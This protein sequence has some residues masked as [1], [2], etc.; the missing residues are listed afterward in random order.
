MTEQRFEYLLKQ[1]EEESLAREMITCLEL[2]ILECKDEINNTYK[3]DDKRVFMDRMIIMFNKQ[4]IKF[5]KRHLAA[6]LKVYGNDEV[7]LYTCPVCTETRG[8]KAWVT[9]VRYCC[10]CGQRLRKP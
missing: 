6:P 8:T 2:E 3:D 5:W 10:D 4:Q 1:D 9:P 7:K